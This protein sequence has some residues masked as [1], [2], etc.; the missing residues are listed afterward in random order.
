[1]LEVTD[2]I[3]LFNH[4]AKYKFLYVK[5]YIANLKIII[6]VVLF[7]RLKSFIHLK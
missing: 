3:K 4:S 6:V 2:Y 5:H 7:C 1:M